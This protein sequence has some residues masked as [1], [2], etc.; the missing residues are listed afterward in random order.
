V[1][2]NSRLGPCSEILR[3]YKERPPVYTLWM[4]IVH[5]NSHKEISRNC[6]LFRELNLSVCVHRQSFKKSTRILL[7]GLWWSWSIVAWNN[8]GQVLGFDFE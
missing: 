6:R 1:G 3:V 5:E 4:F 2:I 7:E 8:I